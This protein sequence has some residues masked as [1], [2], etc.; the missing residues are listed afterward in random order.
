MAKT[1]SRRRLHNE[2]RVCSECFL[3]TILF[4]FDVFSKHPWQWNVLDAEINSCCSVALSWS[5]CDAMHKRQLPTTLLK[6]CTNAFVTSRYDRQSPCRIRKN[7]HWRYNY[8]ITHDLFVAF[9]Q[10][11]GGGRRHKNDRPICLE[12]EQ[13]AQNTQQSIGVESNNNRDYGANESLVITPTSWWYSVTEVSIK[14]I[15]EAT[16]AM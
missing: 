11:G 6:G 10:L 9:D 8:T 7:S 2:K 1:K 3:F 16:K 5:Q 14:A 13:K 15:A 12:A 4:D